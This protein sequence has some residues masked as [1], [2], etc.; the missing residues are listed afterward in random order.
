M[1]QPRAN[2]RFAGSPLADRFW[3]RVVK[4]DTCWLW[5]GGLREGYGV[6]WRD[7]KQMPATHAAWELTYGLVPDG[8]DVL[9]RC[10]NRPCVRPDHLFLGDDFDNQ[11]DCLRKGRHPNARLSY[12]AAEEI[13]QCYSA[14]G[15]TYFQLGRQY[16]VVLQVI[17]RIVKGISWPAKRAVKEGR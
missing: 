2:G 9:H 10:D 12:A 14:G 6:I 4:T 15:W 7:G 8:K 16:G 5:T 11:R 3:R 1:T 13:R 17:G